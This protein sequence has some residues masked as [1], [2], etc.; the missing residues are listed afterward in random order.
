MSELKMNVFK[1]QAEEMVKRAIENFK[2]IIVIGPRQVG[3]STLL[4][5]LNKGQMDVISLDDEVLRNQARTEPS[6]FLQEHPAPLFIDEVQ[7]APELF[8]YI[9][10]NVDKSEER[11]QYWLT[12][13]QPY[14][15]MKMASES[16]AGRAAILNLN[17]FTYS[18]IEKIDKEEFNP[19]NIKEK[20]TINVNDLYEK[21][22]L[23]GMPELYKNPNMNRDLFFSSYIQTY[24]ERDIKDLEQ[25]GNTMEFKK[26]MVAVAT[27]NGEMLNYSNIARDVGI[28]VPKCQTW[29]S[30]LVSSG[31]V[32]L[33]T[34]FYS[35]ELSRL[36]HVPK[37][38]FMDSGLAAYLANWESARDL[39]LS[40]KAGHYLETYIISDIV[41]TYNNKIKRLD[42]SYYRN[43]EKEEVNLIFQKNNILY[44]FEIKKSANPTKDM[45]KNFNDLKK[46]K[47]KIGKGGII[48]LYDKLI[49]LDENNMIIPVSSV[50]S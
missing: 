45:I 49:S 22:F 28:N 19:E 41:K 23:G 11:S 8:S 1:R 3:K 48:C 43:K 25:V 20:A 21:I 16:L 34:P 46:T 4:N 5:D 2:V 50:I 38:V 9:K 31:I 40:D 35:N 6:L 32:Y 24:L 15:L 7:Y 44:P 17:S 37:I 26:F 10:I 39:Q 18:E 14:K 30:I 36:T 29:M 42:I 47:K 13:S 33:L 27:R 12:G